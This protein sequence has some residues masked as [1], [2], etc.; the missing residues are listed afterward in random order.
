MIDANKTMD[1][2]KL[3]FYQ[4]WLY[5]HVYDEGAGG[6]H[7]QITT[8]V[9][10]DYI[11][12]LELPKDALVLDLGCGPGH[13]LDEMKQRG[14]TNLVGVTLSPAD[15]KIC[16]DKG[17]KT[18]QLDLSFLTPY[19][20]ETVDL[21]FL[22]HALEHSPFPIFSLIEYNR[23]LKQGGKIYIEVPAPDNDRPHEFNLNHYSILGERMLA[24]LLQRTG[25]G[26]D[27]FNNFKFELQV[28]V[29]EN[30]EPKKAMEHYYIVVATK[31][32][33]IDIK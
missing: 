21:I 7:E 2:I 10:K 25:F 15:L 11:E 8:Q 18:E 29:D 31:Q 14:Y 33:P 1:L 26:I 23:V 32:Q 9:V 22:R 24:A 16:A 4:E 13:F 28:G 19:N 27:K 5:T 20:D 30:N 17:H 12:P 3:K 6:F